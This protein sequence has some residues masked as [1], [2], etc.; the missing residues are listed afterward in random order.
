MKTSSF[1]DYTG[2]GRISIARSVPRRTPAGFRIFRQLAPGPW[3]NQ[4]DRVEYEHRYQSQL[5]ALDPAFVWAELHRL[6]GEFEPVLL[7]WDARRSPHPTGV[8]GDSLPNG[9]QRVSVSASM[10]RHRSCWRWAECEPPLL[11]RRYSPVNLPPSAVR[12]ECCAI[13]CTECDNAN[14]Q[15]PT[16][17]TQ[18]VHRVAGTAFAQ[19]DT[20]PPSARREQLLD[21]SSKPTLC[22]QPFPLLVPW[23][24]QSCKS[25]RVYWGEVAVAAVARQR[26]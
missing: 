3:F 8:I 13:N 2:P 15:A 26:A 1:F 11:E 18:T 20:M 9:S 23:K 4:L 6:A 10:K 24:G 12:A 17:S 19:L 21:A 14:G 16:R 22:R 25:V 7:C 5:Q